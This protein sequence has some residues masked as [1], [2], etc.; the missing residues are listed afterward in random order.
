MKIVDRE[1][2]MSLP[3]GVIFAKT[4]GPI[5][6]LG[7][8]VKGDTVGGVDFC[9]RQLANWDAFDSTEWAD[10]YDE[11]IAGA[12]FPCDQDFGRDGMFE[13]TDRF[14]VFESPDLIALASTVGDALRANAKAGL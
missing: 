14:L 13:P 10:R 2:F 9:S 3:A 8:S 6:I 7:L 11:M 12:S 1:T 4:T 5:I